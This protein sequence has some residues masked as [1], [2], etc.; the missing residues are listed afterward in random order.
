V[1]LIIAPL[2]S[3]RVFNLICSMRR[4]E[5]GAP[6]IVERIHLVG[7]RRLLPGADPSVG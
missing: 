7:E 6:K 2:S 5:G 3:G 1:S 4:E